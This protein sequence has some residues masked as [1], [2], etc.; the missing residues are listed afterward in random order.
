MRPAIR[1]DR[2]DQDRLRHPAGKIA[3]VQQREQCSGELVS[4]LTRHPCASPADPRDVGPPARVARYPD[5]FG[6]VGKSR[7]KTM[8]EWLFVSP[9][10][11]SPFFGSTY[12]ERGLVS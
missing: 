2:G 4:Q 3:P 5:G 8:I 10:P 6:P 11:Y 12:T 7:G 9:A 1:V